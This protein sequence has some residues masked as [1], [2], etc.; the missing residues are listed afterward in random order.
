[1][2]HTAEYAK[3]V[4]KVRDEMAAKHTKPAVV[5]VGEV[6]TQLLEAF[7]EWAGAILAEGKTLEGAYKAMEDYARELHKKGGNC[8]YLGPDKSMQVLAKYYG[9]KAGKNAPSP[10]AAEGVR[11]AEQNAQET[12]QNAREVAESV[13]KAEPSE[14]AEFDL[15]ALMGGI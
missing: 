1:M 5:S 7:P 6:M 3:A 15:D 8:V 14:M 10:F 2:E 9:V 13:R 4:D 12:A 11:K